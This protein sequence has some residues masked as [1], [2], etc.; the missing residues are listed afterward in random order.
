M[1]VL[2]FWV[3]RFG[4]IYDRYIEILVN[5]QGNSVLA[6][7][8]IVLAKYKML[9]KNSNVG[10]IKCGKFSEVFFTRRTGF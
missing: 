2:N 8:R 5:E 4:H 1:E 3:K 7:D 9:V 6:K 10:K